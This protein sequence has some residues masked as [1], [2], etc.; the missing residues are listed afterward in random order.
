L[1]AEH[2]EAAGE[3]PAA[4]GWHMRAGAWST[5]RN[6]DAARV[7][8][9]RA[10]RIADTLPADDP[11]QLSMRIA[12]RTM[13]CAT[14]WQTGH[15][16]RAIHESRGRFAELRELCGA[17]GDKVSLAIAMTG[18]AT[19][20][21][22]TGRTREGSRLASEQMALLESIGD[23]TLTMALAPP[24]FVL[25]EESGEYGEVLRW[26]Q[27]I[28]DLA[29]GD[30]AKGAGFGVGSPLA[31]AVAHRGVARWW[32]GRPGWRQD[33]HDAVAMA[34]NSN[35]QFFALV[36]LWTY[37]VEI[38]YGVLRADDSALRASE[39]AVHTARSASNDAALSVAEF[40]LGIALLN[41]DAAADCHRGLELMVQALDMWQ[42]ERFYYMVPVTE[43]LAARERVRR[44]D[45]DAALAVMRQAVDELHRAGR[46]GF[47]VWGTGVL[48]ETLLER[49]AE[50]DLAEAQ[51]AFDRLA[52]LPATEGWV[53]CGIWL[54]RLR[55]LL[56]QTRG[57]KASYRDYRDRYRAMATS[58]GFEGHMQ[59]AEA[60]P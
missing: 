8:W 37:G 54:L 20:F 22:Y 2:R 3:L 51:E 30:P 15:L 38:V 50:G 39:E 27:T 16:G 14:G 52:N 43:L 57:D 55:A 46:L 34:R 1:I 48:V 59:W 58:L 9:E 23:P 18:L 40:T 21:L 11:D 25:W 7:S 13:L 24:L 53:V 12:P 32:L 56:A 45:R 35:P 36:V 17:A 26:S 44:G 47:G 42:S 6:L 33:L 4:Y 28:I 41:R 31:V 19:E 60:M 10:R 29:G 5:N 49:G